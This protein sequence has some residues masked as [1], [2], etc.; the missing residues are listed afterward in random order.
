M[1]SCGTVD[2]PPPLPSFTHVPS[3]AAQLRQATQGSLSALFEPFALGPGTMRCYVEA[4]IGL[5]WVLATSEAF[6]SRPC[7]L[8]RKSSRGTHFVRKISSKERGRR[9]F[10]AFCRSHH[11]TRCRFSLTM[12][13]R[14]VV[15]FV[16][17]SVQRW[18]IP[19]S[20]RTSTRRPKSSNCLPGLFIHVM[21]LPRSLSLAPSISC[22]AEKG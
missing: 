16:R 2:T 4:L 7:V 19:Q 21:R 15:A 6:V 3:Q 18:F 14:L 12:E 13:Q 9:A 11:L 8:T 20:K 1:Q 22:S 10:P 5:T 17:C